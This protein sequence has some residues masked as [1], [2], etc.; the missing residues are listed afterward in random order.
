MTDIGIDTVL[1][2]QEKRTMFQM[3]R[4]GLLGIGIEVDDFS[5]FK[6]L[7]K[8]SM[9]KLFQEYGKDFT[10]PVYCANDL[11]NIFGYKTIDE[12]YK[13]L[14]RFK[15][16]ISS[17]I[18]KVHF[19][20][21]YFFG[22]KNNLVSIYGSSANYSKIPLVSADKN[23]QDFYDLIANSYPLICA[24]KLR[25]NEISSKLFLDHFQGRVSPAWECLANS[26]AISVYYKGDQCHELISTA[27]IFVKLIKIKM[28]PDISC[29]NKSNIESLSQLLGANCEIHFMGKKYLREMAP[30]SPSQIKCDRLIKHPIFFLV[31]EDPKDEGEETIIKNS[32]LFNEVIKNV[33]SL[34]GCL[35]YYHPDDTRII[36]PG[37]KLVSF[38]KRGDY[39]FSKLTKLGYKIDKF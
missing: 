3:L 34:D 27:D 16:F 12:E 23:V 36:L 8:N 37:D 29:F 38:G 22:L 21:T 35:K 17:G 18:T 39:I 30:H 14:E 2:T 20:Y 1:L 5:T 10:R 7:Y 31:K 13:V 28:I 15:D 24:W 33:N 6:Q 19:F 11:T 25:K 26:P 9:Q 4:K 32:P